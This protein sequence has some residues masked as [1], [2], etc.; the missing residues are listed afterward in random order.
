M[1][2]TRL[3]YK[4]QTVQHE[5]YK[6]E[7]DVDVSALEDGCWIERW[8]AP[9]ST[10]PVGLD[11]NIS[12]CVNRASLGRCL[13][14]GRVRQRGVPWRLRV[15]RA[16][17]T[18]GRVRAAARAVVT[19]VRRRWTSTT[20]AHPQVG[21][22]SS[23]YS[24]VVWL[25]GTRGGLQFCRPQKVVSCMMLPCHTRFSRHRLLIARP[26]RPPRYV[27]ERLI[28]NNHDKRAILPYD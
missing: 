18:A 25:I 9:H 28:E 23:V 12:W 24:G 3:V 10:F 5:W 21:T 8:R 15:K 13:A 22:G 7:A 26:F 2:I 27:A 6:E 14:G 20:P 1:Y 4:L 11:V 16:P 17:A 19:S